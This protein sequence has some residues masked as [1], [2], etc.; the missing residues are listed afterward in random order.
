MHTGIVNDLN[1]FFLSGVV[2]G[3]TWENLPLRDVLVSVCRSTGSLMH[4]LGIVGS[5]IAGR[6]IGA[7]TLKKSFFIN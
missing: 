3:L 6:A 2:V 4:R 1:L 5:R 7:P